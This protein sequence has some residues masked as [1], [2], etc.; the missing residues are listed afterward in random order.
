MATSHRSARL[1]IAS[2]SIIAAASCIAVDGFECADDRNC[3]RGGVEGVCEPLGV[4][5]YPADDCPSGSRYSP[6]AGTLA[7]TCVEPTQAGVAS[8]ST[9]ADDAGASTDVAASTDT[10]GSGVDTSPA[11]CPLQTSGCEGCDV[12]QSGG[13]TFAVCG[14]TLSWAEARDRCATEGVTLASVHDDAEQAAL[15]EATP[16]PDLFWL[17]LSDRDVEGQWAWVDL[18]PDDFFAWAPGQPDDADTMED[19]VATG[20]DGW[21]TLRCEIPA[22]FVCAGAP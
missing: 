9:T 4:C 16:F 11:G 19:C 2:A 1:R 18:S 21:A 12:V 5:S 3:V 22:G 20:P 17:G 6:N 15:A 7:S 10:Q 8:S 14:E 13:R